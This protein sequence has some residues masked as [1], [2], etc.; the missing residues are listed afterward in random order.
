MLVHRREHQGFGL[1]AET[2][3][4][5]ERFEHGEGL[6]GF[7]DRSTGSNLLVAVIKLLR[8]KINSTSSLPAVYNEQW[9]GC[10]S[11]ARPLSSNCWPGDL[12]CLM[13][14]RNSDFCWTSWWLLDRNSR[15]SKTE[16]RD[17][18]IPIAF[19]AWSFVCAKQLAGGRA[20]E[21]ESIFAWF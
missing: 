1:D 12:S 21:T 2:I 19:F 10:W 13:C 4:S 14:C 8:R 6:V 11:S 18:R 5:L 20:L 9:L 17:P 3:R 15:S 7:A 16:V